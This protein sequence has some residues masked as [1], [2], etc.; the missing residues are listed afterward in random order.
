ME[1]VKESL[2][3]GM[4]WVKESLKAGGFGGL[5]FYGGYPCFIYPPEGVPEYPPHIARVPNP[6]PPHKTRFST[7][8]RVVGT[9]A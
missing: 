4:E 8:E 9:V 7:P 1:W 6:Y 3:A 5:L 2:K